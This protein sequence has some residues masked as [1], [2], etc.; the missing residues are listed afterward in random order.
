MNKDLCKVYGTTNA[1]DQ[2]QINFYDG[3]I[4]GDSIALGRYAALADVETYYQA[5]T[6]NEDK[7]MYLKPIGTVEDAAGIDDSGTYEL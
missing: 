7:I 2:A 1:I 4:Y 5:T 3:T 6:E